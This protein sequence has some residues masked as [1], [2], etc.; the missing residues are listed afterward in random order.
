MPKH[1]RPHT[2]LYK[3]IKQYICIMVHGQYYNPASK[4]YDDKYGET[5]V[6]CDRCKAVNI[7]SCLGH[8]NMD[9]CVKCV[10]QIQFII[11]VNNFDLDLL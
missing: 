11:A 8:N 2:L 6:D 7:T 3:S 1:K 10:K 9:L 4:H 5:N